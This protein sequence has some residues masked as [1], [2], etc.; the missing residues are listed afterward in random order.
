MHV[1]KW[2][3]H[4]NSSSAEIEVKSGLCTTQNMTKSQDQMC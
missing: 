4:T 3:K 2:Q 1:V